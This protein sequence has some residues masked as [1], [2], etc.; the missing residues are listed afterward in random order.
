MTKENSLDDCLEGV[1]EE[2][3]KME[4]KELESAV[5]ARAQGKVFVVSL[6]GP[7]RTEAPYCCLRDHIFPG[8]QHSLH[9]GITDG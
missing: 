7:L 9:T 4:E 8:G 2:E 5:R 3:E 6:G 1:E